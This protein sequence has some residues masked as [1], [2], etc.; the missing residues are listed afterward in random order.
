MKH[1]IFV[2]REFGYGVYDVHMQKIETFFI[3][4]G[5]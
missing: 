1:G 2:C 5:L 3:E 4:P